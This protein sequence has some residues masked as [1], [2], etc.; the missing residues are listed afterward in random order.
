M[1]KWN[2]A[3]QMARYSVVKDD[4]TLFLN[5]DY[6]LGRSEKINLFEHKNF[7]HHFVVY[8]YIYIPA[9]DRNIEVK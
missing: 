8:I 1:E 4:S 3:G 7:T 2:F 9:R 5:G 6:N